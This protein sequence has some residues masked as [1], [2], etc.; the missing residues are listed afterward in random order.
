MTLIFAFPLAKERNCF[1]TTC[2]V[3]FIQD[4]FHASALL[5]T[6]NFVNIIKVD[7]DSRGD[8]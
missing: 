6:M 7:V 1:L 2:D 4:V 5:L 3:I 8:S